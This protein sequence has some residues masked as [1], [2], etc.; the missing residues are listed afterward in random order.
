MDAS[1]CN[2]AESVGTAIGVG[3]VIVLWAAVDIIP[4]VTYAIYRLSRRH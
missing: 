4:G 1:A 3:L 2:N